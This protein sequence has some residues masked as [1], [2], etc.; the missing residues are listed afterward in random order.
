MGRAWAEVNLDNILHNYREFKRISNG[1]AKKT[2]VMCVVKANG[3]GHGSCYIG[4]RLEKEGCDAFGVA[5]FGEGLELRRCGISSSI[6][7]FNHIDRSDIEVALEQN[8]TITVFSKP[9]AEWISEKAKKPAKI[10]IKLD[11]GM[12]RVGLYPDEA[13]ETIKYIH[14]LPNIEIEGAFTH[15]SSA[16]DKDSSYTEL[17][18]SR[19]E[20]IFSELDKTGIQ[21]K[22]KHAASS[23]AAIMY[24][25]T[26]LDMIRCGISLYGYYPSSNVEKS[27]IDLK[28]CMQLKSQI[29]RISNIGPNIPVGYGGLFITE[30]ETK[31]AT[32]TVGYADG[33]HRTAT[34]KLQVLVNGQNAPV[35]GR[36]CMDQCMVDI[37]DINGDVAV[38]DEVVIYGEQKGS[39]ISAE[40]VAAQ[41]GTVHYEVLCSISKRV[42]RYYF[43]NGKIVGKD[44]FTGIFT[45]G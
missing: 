38:Y 36:I 3:Y 17:Q 35:V 42:P 28:P 1:N 7:I 4:K 2:K 27:R 10:H 15:F 11:T 25:K 23:T 20:K 21:I 6:L 33:I 45:P 22:I 26:H 32:I 44:D 43:E 34:G 39:S 13:L 31:L 12:N 18:I 40:Q 14:S 41:M 8:L 9:M 37:T 16:G 30:R 29:V 5:T 24:P 19:L